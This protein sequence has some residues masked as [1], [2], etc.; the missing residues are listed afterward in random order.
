[1]PNKRYISF[2]VIVESQKQ[3]MFLEEAYFGMALAAVPIEKLLPEGNLIQVLLFYEGRNLPM[4]SIG[5]KRQDLEID[6]QN[7]QYL[8]K[9]F[10]LKYQGHYLGMKFHEMDSLIDESDPAFDVKKVVVVDELFQYVQA[11]K[12][13][14]PLVQDNRRAQINSRPTHCR[15]DIGALKMAV[16]L[17]SICE[18]QNEVVVEKSLFNSDFCDGYVRFRGKYAPLISLDYFLRNKRRSTYPTKSVLIYE[19]SS[20]DFVAFAVHQL[21]DLISQDQF[22]PDELLELKYYFD[23]P[24]VQE[25]LNL[26]KQIYKDGTSL[27]PKAAKQTGQRRTYIQF[28]N[29]GAYA[30]EIHSFLKVFRVDQGDGFF[31]QSGKTLNYEGASLPI[32]DFATGDYLDYD[33]R[34]FPEKVVMI[35]QQQPHIFFAVVV[36]RLESILNLFDGELLPFPKVMANVKQKPVNAWVDFC[37]ETQREGQARSVLFVNLD[38]AVSTLNQ[39]A[40]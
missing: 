9:V 17:K 16:D 10:L 20:G 22:K 36:D 18:I 14:L 2:W 40:A 19:G 12:W 11:H 26:H 31:E 23:S 38:L 30:I 13:P 27:N 35:L 39:A 1:M 15:V 24:E 34:A 3:Q 8:S 37:V 7:A 33:L 29:E 32:L 25:V 5:K 4:I 6:A 21:I 28:E